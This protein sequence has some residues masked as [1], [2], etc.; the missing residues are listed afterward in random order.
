MDET[1]PPPPR[2]EPEAEQPAA[3]ESDEPLSLRERLARAAAARHRPSGT[4]G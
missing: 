1:P 2:T 3:A 4:P